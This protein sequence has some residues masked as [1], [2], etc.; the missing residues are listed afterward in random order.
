MSQQVGQVGQEEQ[1][2]KRHVVQHRLKEDQHVEERK[3]DQNRDQDVREHR[4]H[5]RVQ[6]HVGVGQLV[7]VRVE[8]GE[9]QQFQEE[10]KRQTQPQQR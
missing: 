6:V 9:G 1:D 4:I 3:E 2:G 10:R 8:E 5:E 7:R